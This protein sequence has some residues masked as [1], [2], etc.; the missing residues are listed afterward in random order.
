MFH[1]YRLICGR[2]DVAFLN[3]A[4]D[5][6]VAIGINGRFVFQNSCGTRGS[7]GMEATPVAQ[8]LLSAA[9]NTGVSLMFLTL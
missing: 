6:G 8:R 9:D 5:E 1:N 2:P 3:P 7:Q 4:G